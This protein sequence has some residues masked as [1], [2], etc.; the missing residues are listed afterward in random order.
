MPIKKLIFATYRP[1]PPLF[2]AGTEVN[3]RF[4]CNQVASNVDLVCIG[5]YNTLKDLSIYVKELKSLDIKVCKR[6]VFSIEY[7]YN[8]YLCI[9]TSKEKV[10]EVIDEIT[11]EGTKV[12]TQ[13]SGSKDIIEHCKKR[14]VPIC[15]WLHHTVTNF[16]KYF[17]ANPDFIFTSSEFIKSYIDSFGHTSVEVFY[18]TFEKAKL[19]NQNPRYI[20]LI[21]PIYDKGLDVLEQLALAFPNEQFLIV[22]GWVDL[23]LNE[24]YADNIRFIARNHDMDNI[25]QQTK[26]LLSPSRLREGF[27]RTVIEAGL[28][29]I[30]ALTSNLGALP[31]AVGEGGICISTFEIQDWSNA[32]LELNEKYSFYS[33]K[34]KL[35]ALKYASIDAFERLKSTRFYE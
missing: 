22:G 12:I 15:Y 4:F 32:I 5:A 21:N 16:E 14:K 35:N 26:I 18:P 7:I 20:T 27:G 17:N 24:N 9:I 29:G 19:S 23:K 3:Q 25:Y 8:N 10:L 34:A 2:L 1:I 30:P 31:E 6:D 33:E 11:I 13:Q 28:Y